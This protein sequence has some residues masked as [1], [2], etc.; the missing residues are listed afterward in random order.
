MVRARRICCEFWRSWI[1]LYDTAHDVY[2]QSTLAAAILAGCAFLAAGCSTAG[3]ADTGRA[4]YLAGLEA[5]ESGDTVKA[6]LRLT[7][8][9]AELH[10]EDAAKARA[11]LGL[12]ELELD[13][14]ASA[15]E[16]FALAWPALHGE[17][18]RQAA[19]FAAAA[20]R[21]IGDDKT[22]ALWD[23]RALAHVDPSSRHGLFTIQVGA[24]RERHRAERAAVD[25]AEVAEE[26]GFGPVRIVT[27]S[28]R[29]GTALYVV[30]LGSF[31]TRTEA[32]T[33]RAR[34]GNLQYIVAAQQPG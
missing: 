25:A 28:D 30:Q 7:A 16:A 34:V 21:R 8:A 5:Y 31:D 2:R 18:A 19:R 1:G 24:F 20:H 11:T 6:R 3:T 15:A 13:R 33:A 17:D 27:R 23:R 4:D 26:A 29:R 10:G 9:V 32:A 22:A 12:L 14:P